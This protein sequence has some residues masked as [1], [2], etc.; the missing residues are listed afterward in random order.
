MKSNLSKLVLEGKPRFEFDK[1]KADIVVGMQEEE[2]S[3]EVFSKDF[4][5]VGHFYSLLT[6]ISLDDLK[7]KNVYML[8]SNMKGFLEQKFGLEITLI[9]EGKDALIEKLKESD[10]NI[11]LLSLEDLDPRVKIIPLDNKY[12]L[13]DKEGAIKFNF[14]SSVK[15]KDEFILS[16]IAR[17]MGSASFEDA[18]LTKLNMGG[19]VA[20]A[21]NL[22]FKMEAV[23]DYTYPAKEIGDFLADAD[24]THFSN[25]VSFVPGCVPTRSMAFCSSPN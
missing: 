11:A 10:E 9:G 2:G 19:V 3:K 4:I 18:S 21:R 12:Y 13:D 1:K 15:P 17:N 16:V 7:S 24:L 8:D 23:K 6:N 20:I 25:E 22:A 14:Y 5:P